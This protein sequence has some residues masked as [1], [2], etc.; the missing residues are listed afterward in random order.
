MVNAIVVRSIFSVNTQII[1]QSEESM[2][3]ATMTEK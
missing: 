1:F 3:E 2:I